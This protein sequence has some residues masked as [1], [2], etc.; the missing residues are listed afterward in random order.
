MQVLKQLKILVYTTSNLF[1]IKNKG[2]F[3]MLFGRNIRSIKCHKC[4]NNIYSMFA[5]S[6]S[7]VMGS[8]ISIISMP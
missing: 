5:L 4:N 6:H 8:R 1:T 2:I 7:S 3:K